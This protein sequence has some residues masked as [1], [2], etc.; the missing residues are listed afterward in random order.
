VRDVERCKRIKI[1]TIAVLI[2]FPFSISHIYRFDLHVA[3]K[4]EEVGPD[5]EV[6]ACDFP[7]LIV[8][9]EMTGQKSIAWICVV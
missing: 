5:G 6:V 1:L 3:K 8:L 7:I 9:D 4:D 2:F